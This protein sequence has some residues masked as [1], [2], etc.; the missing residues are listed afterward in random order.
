[1]SLLPIPKDT[2]GNIATPLL[3]WFKQ[4]R[5]PLPW[6][7][8]YDPYGVWISEIMLQQTQVEAVLPYY[9]RWMERF[10][11]IESL[12]VAK[13]Q[14]VL[15]AWE[16]LGYYSRAR[17]AHKAAHIL[18]ENFSGR[19]PDDPQALLTLPGIGRYTANAIASI[20]FNQPVPVVDG[21]VA[22]VLGRVFK[23]DA[24]ARS[25]ASDQMLWSFAEKALPAD[26]PRSFNE[27]LM[28]L[29]ALICRPRSPKCPE[30][31]LETLCLAHATSQEEIY[32]RKAPKKPRPVKSGVMILARN[33]EKILV[34]KR[35]QKGLWGGLWEFPWL[36]T[37]R[38]ES[39]AL[40]SARLLDSLGLLKEGGIQPAGTL[41]HVLTHFELT[42]DLHSLRI[43][44]V[45]PAIN[46]HRWV[47]AEALRRLPMARLSR[48]AMEAEVTG[49]GDVALGRNS[50]ILSSHRSKNS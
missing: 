48:K 19:L 31:P 41:T 28:E 13:E 26:S 17:N 12:A 22:R 14:D 18:V 24:P 33:G 3:A 4:A 7:M 34:R 49:L 16:G 11:S 38:G 10:P 40:V 15:K 25:P 21:N 27:G 50:R 32:P 44:G 5:R 36:E 46:G 39:M 37:N 29:G 2:I 8:Q 42:L 1:M 43:K 9:Q 6:R 20:A 35:P 45:F 47:S 30:C 23:I